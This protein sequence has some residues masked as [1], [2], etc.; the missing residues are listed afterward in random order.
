MNIMGAGPVCEHCGFDERGRNA[1]N[2]LPLGFV[3]ADRYTVGRSLGQGGYGIT[4]LCWDRHQQIPVVIKEYYPA[5]YVMRKNNGTVVPSSFHDKRG[6]RFARNRERF[7]RAVQAYSGASS[8]TGMAR[9]YG[10]FIA[11]NTVYAVMEYVRGTTLRSY[12]QKQGGQLSVDK[13][14]ELLQPVME[15]LAAMHDAGL[16]HGRVSPDS[17][18]LLPNGERKLVDK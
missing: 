15:T 12:L 3:L 4:Y 2:H 5:M 9:I 16:I 8:I 10:Y 17:I 13:T 18:I 1:S 11:N 6:E 14:V 7:L